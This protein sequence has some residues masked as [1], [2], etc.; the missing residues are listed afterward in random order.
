MFE[1]LQKTIDTF[2]GDYGTETLIQ[3]LKDYQKLN[4]SSNYKYIE[5]VCKSV[6]IA[7]D[8]PQNSMLDINN[9][10]YKAV[11]ARRHIVYFLTMDKSLPNKVITTLFKCKLQTVYNYKR[12]VKERMVNY[13]IFKDFKKQ[14]EQI[15]NIID[16]V[17]AKHQ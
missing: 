14:Y 16:N 5:T 17:S 2:I 6:S 7:C 13:H 12:D 8:I 11:D 15:K 3:Y 9:L 1:N 4:I 10:N